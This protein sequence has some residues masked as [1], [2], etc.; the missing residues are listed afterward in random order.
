MTQD[1]T[2]EDLMQGVTW[3]TLEEYV[4]VKVQG[5]VQELLEEEVTELL[6]RGKSERRAMVDAPAGYRNGYGKPRH[7]TLGSGTI[8]VEFGGHHTESLPWLS[9]FAPGSQTVLDPCAGA[10]TGPSGH[11]SG[12]GVAG[13][14]ATPGAP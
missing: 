7:L 8:T 11:A 6:G 4:R 9:S 2:A 14:A 1:I 13:P 5:F 3:E 10:S 12:E